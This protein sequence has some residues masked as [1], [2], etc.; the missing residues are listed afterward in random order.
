MES[1]LARLINSVSIYRERD[2]FWPKTT[3]IKG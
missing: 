1:A 3:A 2:T